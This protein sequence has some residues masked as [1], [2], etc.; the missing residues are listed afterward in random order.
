[1]SAEFD[2]KTRPDRSGQGS[3]KWDEMISE[4]GG[5]LPDGVVPL[6]VADMELEIAPQIKR[7]LHEFVDC[8]VPGYTEP[9]DAY[10]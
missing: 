6:S 9:T 1:M 5:E 8:V 7:A 2:F 10:Y 4:A 3:S